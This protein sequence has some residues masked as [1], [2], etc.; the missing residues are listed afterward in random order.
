M[1]YT[2]DDIKA[3]SIQVKELLRNLL[4]QP[5]KGNYSSPNFMV[6]NAV[7]KRRNKA[8]MDISYQKP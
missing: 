7:E 2:S 6:M 5:T 8:R 1:L 4:I 3:F